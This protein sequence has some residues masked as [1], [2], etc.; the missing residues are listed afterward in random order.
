[1]LGG[2]SPRSERSPSK[3]PFLGRHD[4]HAR[5]ETRA[6]MSG[7]RPRPLAFGPVSEWQFEGDAT[8][9]RVQTVIPGV[10]LPLGYRFSVL[11]VD[12]DIAVAS[13]DKRV[14][15]DLTATVFD[16]GG[17]RVDSVDA[18]TQSLE[19]ESGRVTYEGAVFVDTRGWS[20]GRYT[21]ELRLR[22]ERRGVAAD[23]ETTA[24][25]VRRP[26][27]TDQVELRGVE[28][29]QTMSPGDSRSL[30]VV[31][32]NVTAHDG[33][34]RTPLSVRTPRGRWVRLGDALGA[35]VPA[36]GTNG[37]SR[38]LSYPR[39]GQLEILVPVDGRKEW[40]ELT[41]DEGGALRLRLDDFDYAW[42]ITIK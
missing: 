41:P 7:P 33:G 28:S 31:F 5:P 13:A 6:S 3:R 26:L 32:E 38:R 10:Q 14:V 8:G 25:D 20:T 37:T 42:E 18:T 4:H 11:P 22:D 17:R 23:P 1:M 30:R 12:A 36:G 27:E 9:N 34:V 29:P 16:D 2:Q 19:S 15:V 35:L 39:R 40:T 21:A 24:F